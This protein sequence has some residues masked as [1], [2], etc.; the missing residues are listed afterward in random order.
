LIGVGAFRFLG[1]VI[2]LDAKRAFI[3]PQIDEYRE[4]LEARTRSIEFMADRRI[5]LYGK[6]TSI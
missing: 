5:S 4:S 3:G 6:K 1:E 2:D